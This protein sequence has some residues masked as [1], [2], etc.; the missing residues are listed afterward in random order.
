MLENNLELIVQYPEDHQG[1]NHYT[2]R[3]FR[4]LHLTTPVFLVFES[5]LSSAQDAAQDM[6]EAF[7]EEIL[8]YA[9]AFE[10]TAL[11]CPGCR[12]TVHCHAMFDHDCRKILVH[13]AQPATS[14]PEI[15]PAQSAS[16]IWHDR[17]RAWDSE[18]EEKEKIEKQKYEEEQPEEAKKHPYV[19]APYPPCKWEVIPILHTTDRDNVHLCLPTLWRVINVC[20][21]SFS[22]FE[23]L[24]AVLQRVGLAPEESRIFISYVR[25]ETSAIADQLF[26]ALTE[27]GFD[28][29]LDRCSVPA[30]VNFQQ[31]L[32]QDLCDKAM[33]ILLNS[34]R[35][36]AVAPDKR[37]RWVEQ[38]IATIKN[39]RLGLLEL[40]LPGIT[41]RADIGPDSTELLTSADLVP[42]GEDYPRTAQKLSADKLTH[43]ISRIRDVHGQALHR[44]R[45]ELIGNLGLALTKAGK[46]H[47]LQSD[48]TFALPSATQPETIIGLTA[49]PPELQNYFG[50]GERHKVS[51]IRQGWL[52]SPAPFFEHQRQAQIT[53]LGGVSKIQH[54]C[55]AQIKDMIA[56]L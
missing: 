27:A 21:W 52:I 47:D 34:E 6:G 56:Q 48:G 10:V 45:L 11:S 36:S 18:K 46:C 3:G 23:I 43:V 16:G 26:A 22:R 39:Y 35:V 44:R 1:G 13:F 17:L 8:K 2:C 19:P 12:P 33:V 31:R 14:D 30:A 15:L 28:V 25:K 4:G 29:F 53:W 50:L 32:M 41:Q 5:L 9:G 49:R 42:A 51:A 55:E 54:A 24:W 20:F 38:E 7:C 37:S 40:R